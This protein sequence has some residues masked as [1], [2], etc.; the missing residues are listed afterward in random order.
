MIVVNLRVWKRLLPTWHLTRYFWKT[1][2]FINPILPMHMHIIITVVVAVA[3]VAANHVSRLR[4]EGVWRCGR[5]RKPQFWHHPQ[6][7][8]ER[9]ESPSRPWLVPAAVSGSMR[10]SHLCVCVC[11]CVCVCAQGAPL[12]VWQCGGAFEQANEWW[13]FD[14]VMG[15]LISEQQGD[16]E[17]P[18]VAS[19]CTPYWCADGDIHRWWWCC[20]KFIIASTWRASLLFFLDEQAQQKG[21]DITFCY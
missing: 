15:H 11:V 16:K 20:W 7:W 8:R 2:I 21:F 18:F 14:P 3:I 12:G 9:L 17:G 10:G 4:A 6:P 1:Q 5:G 13:I 19:V